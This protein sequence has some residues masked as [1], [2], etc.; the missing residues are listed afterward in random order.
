MPAE[1]LDPRDQVIPN[2]LQG[3]GHVAGVGRLGHIIVGA[4]RQRLQG[5]DRAP[6]G[7]RAEHDHRQAGLALADF[8]QR[9]QAVHFRHL[10]IENHQIRVDGREFLQRHPTVLGLAGNFQHRIA[11]QNV[12]EQ[13]ADQR[14]IIDEHQTNFCGHD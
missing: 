11:R 5:D 10:D 3:R 4:E 7:H 9:F 13:S 6:L 8:G 2:P 14:R 1:G 12:S